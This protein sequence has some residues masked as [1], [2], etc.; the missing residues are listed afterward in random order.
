M[1]GS[2]VTDDPKEQC[3][4]DR[5]VNS[6]IMAHGQATWGPSTENMEWHLG[7]FRADMTSKLNSHL[8]RARRGE[9]TGAEGNAEHWPKAKKKK[10]L[11]SKNGWVI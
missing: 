3:L 10:G 2:E 9:G 5:H 8:R 11:S 6:E 7:E 1:L 4:P